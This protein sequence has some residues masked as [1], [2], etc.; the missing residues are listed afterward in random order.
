M[1]N[2]KNLPNNWDLLPIEDLLLLHKSGCWGD[3]SN[4]EN[5]TPVLRSTNFTKDF[6]ITYN[7]VAFM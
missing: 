6:K 1:I 7:K 2:K 3:E 5:G 4:K